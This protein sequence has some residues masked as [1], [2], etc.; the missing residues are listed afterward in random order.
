MIHNDDTNNDTVTS[1]AYWNNSAWVP[2]GNFDFSNSGG[3]P[4]KLFVFDS[5]LY[6]AGGFLKINGAPGNYIL[7]YNSIANSWDSI[8]YSPNSDIRSFYN[9][10]NYLYLGGYFTTF[11]PLQT[12]GVAIYNPPLWSSIPPVLSGMPGV[13]TMNEFNH[14]L[15]FAGEFPC[16]NISTSYKGNIIG[17]DGFNFIPLDNGLELAGG[18][19]KIIDLEVYKNKLYAAGPF[20]AG[21]VT[22]SAHIVCWDGQNWSGAS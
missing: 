14:I 7:A 18:G 9:Y 4:Y 16:Y 19:D 11:G 2:I 22:N 15:I 13:E 21:N 12:F 6:V 8:V 5:T 3:F 20:D 17:W 1:P 10:N